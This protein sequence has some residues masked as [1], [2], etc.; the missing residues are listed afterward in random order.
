MEV[1]KVASRLGLADQ[2]LPGISGRFDYQ[3][4]LELP[5]GQ[6]P[7]LA[8]ST[9]LTGVIIDWPA[10]LGKTAGAAAP[11]TIG[12]RQGLSWK[13]LPAAWASRWGKN[14]RFKIS[15]LRMAT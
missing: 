10:P 15:H 6:Q 8:L 2:S 5:G 1:T 11:L 13:V 7:T 3:A 9:D 12:M 14:D 4:L